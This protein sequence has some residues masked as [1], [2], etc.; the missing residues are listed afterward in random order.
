MQNGS[1]FFAKR[2]MQQTTLTNCT[3]LGAAAAE[4]Y[5]LGIGC[6]LLPQIGCGLCICICILQTLPLFAL[7][8][9]SLLYARSSSSDILLI[10]AFY[11]LD[12]QFSCSSCHLLLMTWHR[13]HVRLWLCCL[14]QEPY[15]LHCPHGMLPS[16]I[17]QYLLCLM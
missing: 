1:C 14:L 5:P 12:M 15:L 3:P 7:L 6:C 9:G 11:A 13:F 4:L 16:F 10:Y 2:G 17:L 8:C